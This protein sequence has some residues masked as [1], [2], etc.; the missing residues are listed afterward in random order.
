MYKA[1]RYLLM[2]VF[3][4]I[5][6][7]SFA[8]EIKSKHPKKDLAFEKY[9]IA[10]T[11]L[12][13]NRD[14][15]L[16]LKK[17]IEQMNASVKDTS[18]QY[19]VLNLDAYVNYFNQNIQAAIE[20]THQQLA[21]A[22]AA[23]DTLKTI[24]SK[25]MLAGFYGNVGMAD[26]EI[27]LY[28]ECL[29]DLNSLERQLI[30]KSSP[31][32]QW[33]LN[34]IHATQNNLSVKYKEMGKWSLAEKYALQ[35]QEYFKGNQSQY[36]GK[37]D[38]EHSKYVSEMGLIEIYTELGKDS[39]ALQYFRS[40]LSFF[41]ERNDSLYQAVCYGRIANLYKERQQ[42][43]LAEKYFKTSQ[44]I[45]ELLTDVD[46][47]EV[48]GNFIKMG[49]IKLAQNMPREALIYANNALKV[50]QDQEISLLPSIL[51][52][53]WNA[54]K[55]LGQHEKALVTYQEYIAIND[56]ISS[57]EKKQAIVTSEL[58]YKFK[59]KEALDS[60]KITQ[61]SSDLVAQELATQQANTRNLF[62]IIIFSIVGLGGGIFILFALNRNKIIRS[63]KE[64]IRNEYLNLKEFTENASHEMQTPMAVIQSKLEGLFELENLSEKDI[65]N[66]ESAYVATSRMS[67]LNAS[68]LLLTK[69]ENNQ[70]PIEDEI[71]LSE[72]VHSFVDQFSD[73][74]ESKK[75]KLD[76]II[77]PNI[78]KKTNR[79]LA[80]TLVSNLLSNA[81]RH[82]VENGSLNIEL[83]ENG[84][85]VKNTGRQLEIDVNTLFDRFTKGDP[86]SN[87]MGLGLSITKRCC[88]A[89]NWDIRYA[90][91][92]GLHTLQVNFV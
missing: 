74:I 67:E 91:Q 51:K 88:E 5:A 12:R 25:G 40:S 38:Q 84:L 87:S 62:V 26:V 15:V 58:T 18:L 22:E 9:Q 29:L 49:E 23:D 21:L 59:K 44:T 11:L 17:E 19:L 35:S 30:D 3:L 20:Y 31:R 33:V 41:E 14:S 61:V 46:M 4:F 37:M 27:K 79:F 36:L 45:Y 53:K 81:V 48:S 80:D 34:F 89:H 78:V 60:I 86:T 43:L 64:I 54:Q 10:M 57:D 28:H 39:L 70:F 92:E 13:S 75:I 56:R 77:S 76:L 73:F 1:G 42:F 69:I 63:Q 50:I 55:Q 68:L 82:N 71:N 2:F 8:N 47:A 72:T 90:H 52:I 32:Y 65:S 85:R 83:N 24:Q 7:T 16:V 6:F 66:I